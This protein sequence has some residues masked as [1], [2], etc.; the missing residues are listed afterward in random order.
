MSYTSTGLDWRLRNYLITPDV[1]VCANTGA[2]RQIPFALFT[3]LVGTITF[4]EFVIGTTNP[5]YPRATYGGGPGT[6]SNVR[7]GEFFLNQ[8]FAGNPLLVDLNIAA[9]PPVIDYV[10]ILA[11]IV[12]D[13]AR[14]G[15]PAA[16]AGSPG[17][18]GPQAF[19][20]DEDVVGVKFNV[21][22][23]NV[24]NSITINVFD[25]NATVLFSTT[26]DWVGYKD[27]CFNRDSNIANIAAV[28][29]SVDTALE[30]GTGFSIKNIQF[31]QT[32]A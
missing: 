29:F 30:G 3:P 22:F 18:N 7:C 6:P 25:R 32:C 26:N 16:F 24:L 27:V 21:G 1:A 8:A 17:F 9:P 11:R 14:P 13:G 5:I 2:V 31:S 12:N 10:S 28:Q 19:V 20:F 23:A 15:N 4:E